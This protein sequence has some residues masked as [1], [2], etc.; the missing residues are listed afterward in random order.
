MPPPWSLVLATAA[1]AQGPVAESA[2]EFDSKGKPVAV[3]CFEPESFG[4]LPAIVILYG[5]G[6][7]EPPP[8]GEAFRELARALAGRGFAVYLPHYFD[9]TGATT[10][11]RRKDNDFS[12]WQEAVADAV[13]YAAGR[14]GVDPERI[15]LLGMSLGATLSYLHAMKDPRIKAL[16]ALSGGVPL[17]FGDRL[18]KLPPVLMLNG[19]AD[20]AMPAKDRPRIEAFLKEHKI[21][22]TLHV[23]KGMGHNFDMPRLADAARRAA[24]FFDAH[25]KPGPKRAAPRPKAKGKSPSKIPNPEGQAPDPGTPKGEGEEKSSS[26]KPSDEPPNPR[27]ALP[28]E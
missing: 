22:Y 20:R 19:S 25:L 7:L 16:V 17:G 8:S 1:L 6:G 15:G 11:L 4:R 21:P 23:Y 27:G 18:D 5:S 13:D 9:R 26:P 3:E 2:A 14:P 10:A 28:D 12:A 24:N